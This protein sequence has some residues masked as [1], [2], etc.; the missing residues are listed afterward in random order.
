MYT[1]H[2]CWVKF[3]GWTLL[4]R[5]GGKYPDFLLS[6]SQK[7]LNVFTILFIYFFFFF[8]FFCFSKYSTLRLYTF[9]IVARALVVP[10]QTMKSKQ[11]NSGTDTNRST[12]RKGKRKIQG[13]PQ[14]QTA[15]PRGRGNRQNQTSANRTS[16]RK[17]LRLA[18]SL[19]LKRGNRNV[20]RTEKH[21][22]TVTQGKT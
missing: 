17:A 20:K 3:L 8:F 6:L 10:L 11:E 2:E 12:S 22:N 9:A 18:L 4:L 1:N 13:V 14:S 7:P 19:F 21:K 15:A 16:V 5:A